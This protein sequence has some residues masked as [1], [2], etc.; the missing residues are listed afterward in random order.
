MLR[1][2]SPSSG[3]RSGRGVVFA[4]DQPKRQTLPEEIAAHPSH[5]EPVLKVFSAAVKASEGAVLT[6]PSQFPQTG[7]A[8]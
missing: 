8:I 6:V 3:R 5:V 1:N 2:S 4:D 7:L